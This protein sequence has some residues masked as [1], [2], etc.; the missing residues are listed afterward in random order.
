MKLPTDRNW[1]IESFAHAECR[2][3]ISRACIRNA[4]RSFSLRHTR[5]SD[6]RFW[7]RFNARRQSFAPIEARYRKLRAMLRS[8]LIQVTRRH[9]L[10][11][12]SILLPIPTDARS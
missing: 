4:G 12:L 2:M 9:T 5:A 6:F 11:R 3:R 10:K 1:Q 8:W 7:K